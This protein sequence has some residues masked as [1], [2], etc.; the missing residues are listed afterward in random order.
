MR[1]RGVATLAAVGI[2][3]PPNPT[4]KE[5][6]FSDYLVGLDQDNKCV[7]RSDLGWPTDDVQQFC[8]AAGLRYSG[9]TD[10]GW[11]RTLKGSYPPSERHI[12][13]W[14]SRFQVGW[15]CAW[16]AL[17][18]FVALAVIVNIVVFVVRHV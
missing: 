18:V 10:L 11:E 2:A 12:R 13:L 16:I 14:D 8:K 5:P 9:H 4:Y 15:L 6:R 17:G 3:F 7:F 1:C